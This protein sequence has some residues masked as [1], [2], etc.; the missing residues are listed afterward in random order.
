MDPRLAG[1]CNETASESLAAAGG[2]KST[3]ASLSQQLGMEY[4]TGD[5]GAKS[6]GEVTHRRPRP[7]KLYRIGDV[8][9]YAEVS[10]QTIHNYTVM[11]LL[12]ESKWTDGGHR[13]YDDSVFERLDLI[14]TLRQQNWPLVDIKERLDEVEGRRRQEGQPALG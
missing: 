4:V 11:G 7:P 10:R 9:G 13:L 8:V 2:G 14:E 6:A 3:A 5:K 12:R 1:A